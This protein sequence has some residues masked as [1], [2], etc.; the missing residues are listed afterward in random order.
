MPDQDPVIAQKAPFEVELEAG[1]LQF[2]CACGRSQSQ[3][4]C[5]GSHKGTGI[6]PLR[7][8]VE[9]TNRYFLCGCKHSKNPP[10]CDG[11]HRRLD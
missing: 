5:D 6:T 2:W 8:E 10:F 3:P 1:Q 9:E 4:Y 11:S 7:V